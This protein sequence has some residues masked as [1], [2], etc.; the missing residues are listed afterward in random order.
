MAVEIGF[1]DPRS[2]EVRAL[3]AIHLAFSRAATPAEYSFAM[4]SDDLADPAVTFFSARRDGNLV[5]IAALKHLD[6]A[7]AE[8]KSMHTI[9]SERRMGVARSLLEHILEYA[10]ATGY[11]RLSL[12]TGSTDEFVPARALYAER[13]FMRCEPFAG[14]AESSYNTFMTLELRRDQPTGK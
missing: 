1:D 14:Y 6:E 9:D 13:G 5:G 11:R 4:D 3:L 8:L 12:E 7:H 2:E 10:R